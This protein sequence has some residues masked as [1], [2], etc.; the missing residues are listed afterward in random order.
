MDTAE[1]QITR[2]FKEYYY[3]VDY[4]A[5]RIMQSREA[6]GP[7]VELIIG[8]SKLGGARPFISGISQTIRAILKVQIRAGRSKYFFI[9]VQRDR[10]V[11]NSNCAEGTSC[12]LFQMKF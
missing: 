1:I 5:P 2:V 9:V 8:K 7:H 4:R 3:W 10:Q 12:A 6:E 11:Y